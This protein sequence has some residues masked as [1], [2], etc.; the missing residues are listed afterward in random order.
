MAVDYGG[1]DINAFA[2]EALT[3]YNHY[4]IAA[5]FKH[6]GSAGEAIVGILQTQGTIASGAEIRLRVAGSAKAIFG[7]AVSKGAECAV[8]AN[9]KLV[10]AAGANYVCAICDEAATAAGDIRRVIVV[11]YQKNA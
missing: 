3:D 2:G 1:L 9:G 5:D 10:A 6:A 11:N 7:G 8:D 4:P